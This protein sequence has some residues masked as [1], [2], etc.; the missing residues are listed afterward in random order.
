V[1]ERE[2]EDEDAPIVLL[3]ARA[4]DVVNNGWDDM[5]RRDC[6]GTF[7]EC[8]TEKDMERFVRAEVEVEAPTEDVDK[9]ERD[10]T[11][12]WVEDDDKDAELA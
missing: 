5:E 10:A 11:V 2:P 1:E 8:G 7:E 3:R 6:K 9:D 4:G 12:D